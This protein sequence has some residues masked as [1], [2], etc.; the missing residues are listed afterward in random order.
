MA[1]VKMKKLRVV[2]LSSQREQLLR[3]L[4]RMGCVEVSQPE[5]RLSDP[6]WAALLHRENSDLPAMR[7]RLAE[8]QTA[9][10]ALGK[11]SGVKYGLF[12]RRRTVREEE[13]LGDGAVDEAGAATDR[14]NGLLQML[15]R[16]QNEESGLAAR[17]AALL[18]WRAS[19]QSR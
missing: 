2:A 10:D 19:A 6:H 18:P 9:L 4:L 16:L 12:I 8:V 14:I 17:K 3:Q 13:F 11:Y 5:E 1:I 15:S 7:T